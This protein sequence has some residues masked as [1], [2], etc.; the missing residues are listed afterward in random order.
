MSFAAED[1]SL[2]IQAHKFRE[3]HI[4]TSL[5]IALFPP[6]DHSFRHIDNFKAY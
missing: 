4:L 5:L 2:T 1:T 6:Q 3:I